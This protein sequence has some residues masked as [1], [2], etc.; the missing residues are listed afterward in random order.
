M[1]QPTQIARV[2][3]PYR[4]ARRRLIA[5]VATAAAIVFMIPQS[6][7]RGTPD[8]FAD[9]AKK[10]TPAVVNV[11]T[12][13]TAV[14][15]N[16]VP[17][18]QFPQGTPFDDMFR[19]FFQQPSD[20]QDDDATP[21]P[22]PRRGAPTTA[23][24]SGF[25]IDPAGYIVTNN[26]VVARADKIGVTLP[27]GRK[28][29]ARLVGRDEKTDLALLGQLDLGASYNILPCVSLFASYRVMGWAGVANSDRKSTRL[30]SSH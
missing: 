13:S 26:H 11:S 6:F 16:V 14:V 28:F 1:L 30:N 21:A 8:G 10:V 12:T 19:R 15:Q 29:D 9:L 20:E 27:D 22:G 3:A 24:G 25:I 23:L 7:A 5:G 4:T 2:E 17:F 18:P